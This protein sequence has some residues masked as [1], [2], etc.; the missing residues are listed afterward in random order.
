MGTHLAAPT[1][2]GGAAATVD[3]IPVR[4]L[5][6]PVA[7]IRSS[8]DVLTE[9]GLH[10]DEVANGLIPEGALVALRTGLGAAAPDD[11]R[12]GGKDGAGKLVF[13]GWSAEAIRFLAD[14]RRVVAIATDAPAIDAGSAVIAAPAQ[15]AGSK[16]GL[17]FVVSLGD[18]RPL[19]ARGA[20][21]VVGVVPITGGTGAQCRVIGLIPPPEP[22]AVAPR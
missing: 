16:R 6:L 11:P 4:Q 12:Y 22:R 2:R 15:T 5:V 18:L 10:A 21:V 9:A 14:E 1:A 20:Y 3:R 17:W 7:V 8:G 19:P 13:P